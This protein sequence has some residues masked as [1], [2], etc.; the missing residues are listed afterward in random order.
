MASPKARSQPKAGK[1][2]Q[3]AAVA[4][5]SP[6]AGVNPASQDT[7]KISWQFS[8][9][10]KDHE[11][12]GWSK[13]EAQACWEMFTS[14]HLAN[15]E[16]MT[17]RE[18]KSASGG[19]ANGTNSHSIPVDQLSKEA[20]AR[21]T[22]LKLDDQ[23]SIFSMRLTGTLRIFGFQ[24]GSAFKVLWHDPNHEVCPSQKKNT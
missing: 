8:R 14:G 9:I 16:T 17:W 3:G 18:I 24:A 20:Q 22:E 10:D 13:L 11:R 1:P 5:G 23:D 19:K 12:W 7:Q 4:A 6:R 2:R 21:L 15:I